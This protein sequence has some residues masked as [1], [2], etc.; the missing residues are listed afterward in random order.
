MKAIQPIKALVTILLTWQ[1]ACPVVGAAD[2]TDSEIA[3]EAVQT[4]LQEFQAGNLEIAA[5]KFEQAIALT[6]DDTVIQFNQACVELAKGRQD[7]AKQKLRQAMTGTNPEVVQAA[8]YNLGF[9]KVQ[10]VR[11]KLQ[12]DPAAVPK[13]DRTEIVD[14][15]EQAARYFRNTLEINADHQDAAYNLELIRMYLKQLQ[16][17]WNQQD[18]QQQQPEESLA[19]LL[20]R[21]HSAFRESEILMANLQTEAASASHQTA[22]NEFQAKLQEIDSDVQTVRPLFEQWVQSLNQAPA[23][24]NQP[25]PQMSADESAAIQ[26][27]T[28]LVEHLEA[29]SENT[30]AAIATQDWGL[31]KQSANESIQKAHQLFLNVASYQEILQAALTR[32]TKLKSKSSSQTPVNLPADLP[33]DG[34]VSATVQDQQFISDF[35]QAISIQAEQRLPQIQQQLEQ[36]QQKPPTAAQNQPPPGTSQAAAPAASVLQA[37]EQEIILQGLRESMQRAIQ[38]TPDAILYADK[39][40]N[41]MLNQAQ[42]K[43]AQQDHAQ[44]QTQTLQWAQGKVESLLQDIAE[45]LQDPDSDQQQQQ[46]SDDQNDDRSE[47]SEDQSEDQSESGEDSS[48]SPEQ[49]SEDSTDDAEE[50]AESES[51]DQNEEGD[52]QPLPEMAQQQAE[53]ILRKATEREQEYLELKKLQRKQQSKAAVKKDW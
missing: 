5:Q 22:V 29:A 11:A 14:E 46:Q 3:F 16:T 25:P 21:L 8:H 47:D 31:G 15:L 43:N 9:L 13:K 26:A 27:L 41:M 35:S 30:V 37:D 4:G 6:A 34:P 32:Q 24:Q 23:V 53:A 39:S 45:P 19:D 12:P 20:I 7:N 42:T 36:L 17:M 18:D 40:A 28:E 44:P 2:L 48:E 38:L 51:T 10:Q 50:S 49:Q 33:V 1:I 52:Q